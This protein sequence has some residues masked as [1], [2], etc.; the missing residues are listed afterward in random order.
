[1]E[2]IENFER[3]LGSTLCVDGVFDFDNGENYPIVEYEE[4]TDDGLEH[5]HHYVSK[6]LQYLSHLMA[7]IHRVNIL[8]EEY[9]DVLR[10]ENVGKCVGEIIYCDDEHD[11]L[12]LK[13]MN[14]EP[15]FAP[16][17]FDFAMS[18]CSQPPL[19]IENGWYEGR[20]MKIA[21]EMTE[22]GYQCTGYFL[23]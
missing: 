8:N 22:R 16:D 11:H 21:M 2:I 10:F 9:V 3:D 1:M 6:I 7:P 17:V 12:V 13:S 23:N 15:I 20:L 19:L 18:L 5:V 14:N 4:V